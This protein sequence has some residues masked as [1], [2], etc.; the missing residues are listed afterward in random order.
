M[1][2]LKKLFGQ[3]ISSLGSVFYTF[4][5]ACVLGGFDFHE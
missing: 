3:G 5:E 4:S 2:F 1:G